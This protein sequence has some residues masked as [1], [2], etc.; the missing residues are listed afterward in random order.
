[1]MV[2]EFGSRLKALRQA[3]G[4]RQEDLA[5]A[6]DVSRNTVIRWESGDNEP[7]VSEI[8]KIAAVLDVSLDELMTGEQ[9]KAKF[10]EI[11]RGPLTLRLPADAEGY[12]VLMSKLEEMTVSDSSPVQSS[13]AG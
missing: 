6:L 10:I 7:R 5:A 2:N 9:A 12:A 1:M 4:I 13:K 3:K 8:V 11:T